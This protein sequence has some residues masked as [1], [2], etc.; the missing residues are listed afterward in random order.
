MAVSGDGTLLRRYAVAVR[1][2]VC[3]RAHASGV[4]FGAKHARVGASCLF[5]RVLLCIP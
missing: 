4:C 5:L 1:D 3:D 2:D